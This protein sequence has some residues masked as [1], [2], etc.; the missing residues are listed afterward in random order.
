MFYHC[1]HSYTMENS[2]EKIGATLCNEL[3]VSL[4]L[5]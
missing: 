2:G 3:A 4:P 5:K 1:L